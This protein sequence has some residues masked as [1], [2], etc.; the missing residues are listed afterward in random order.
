M[1]KLVETK[2]SFA[3]CYGEIALTSLQKEVQKRTAQV[4]G[5]IQDTNYSQQTVKG[6]SW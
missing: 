2:V 5:L 3:Q 6:M 1:P 4:E